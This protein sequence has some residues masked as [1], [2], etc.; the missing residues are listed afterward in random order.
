LAY[1]GKFAKGEV[2]AETI[3]FSSGLTVKLYGLKHRDGHSPYYW[4]WPTY[5]QGI[6]V[7]VL[8]IQ[9][10][11]F[12]ADVPLVHHTGPNALSASAFQQSEAALSYGS[13]TILCMLEF[14]NKDGQ[15]CKYL[16]E[17]RAIALKSI[18]VIE[19]PTGKD[20]DLQPIKVNEKV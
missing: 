12:R 20:L 2:M 3:V 5:H 9:D 19:A 6:L 15:R 8:S 7:P 4:V 18:Y 1:K 16:E 14:E 10:R 11:I 13:A 17:W